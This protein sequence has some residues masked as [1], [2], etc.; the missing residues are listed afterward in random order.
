MLGGFV[1]FAELCCRYGKRSRRLELLAPSSWISEDSPMV[2]EHYLLKRG[3]LHLLL[4]F[5]NNIIDYQS[6]E[7]KDFIS[8]ISLSNFTLALE[9]IKAPKAFFPLYFT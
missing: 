7:S 6:I 9:S 2:R 4:F 3:E 8:D 1:F 5:M